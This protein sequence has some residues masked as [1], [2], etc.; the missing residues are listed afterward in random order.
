M[1]IIALVPYAR[2]LEPE[3]DDALRQLEARGVPVRKYRG[4]SQIDIARCQMATDALADGFTEILWVD[5]DVVFRADDAELLLSHNL[6]F[7]CGV[8][9]KKGPRQLACEFL[10]GLESVAFGP[11]GGLAPLR[12][13]GFGFALTRRE[14]FDRVREF[15]RLPTLNRQFAR[16]LVPYFAPLWTDGDMGR[17]LGEDYAF[18]ERV[19]RAGCELW[20]DTRVRLWHMGHYPYGWEDAGR[21]PQRF[22][23]YRYTLPEA[24]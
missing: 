15:H 22:G 16:P 12:Y 4:Y 2:H 13:A 19:T 5:S 6:P 11:E 23:R 3:C 10:P 14:L 7:V 18:C 21:E 20:A 24:K 17:Y 8:Y 1:P 9:A